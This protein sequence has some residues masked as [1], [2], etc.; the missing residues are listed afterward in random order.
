MAAGEHP[1]AMVQHPMAIPWLSHGYGWI[2]L[3]SPSESDP[4]RELFAFRFISAASKSLYKTS[5][6]ELR[7][8][9]Y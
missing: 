5:A 8:T 4:E 2:D 1:M 9:D 7:V 6:Y 3:G